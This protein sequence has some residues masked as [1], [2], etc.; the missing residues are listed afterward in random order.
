MRKIIT[1]IAIL[2]AG[3]SAFAQNNP[4]RSVSLRLGVPVGFSYQIYTGKKDH[5]EFVLGGASPYWSK[6]YYINSFNTF[7]KY[8]DFKYLDHSVKNTIFLQ[9]RYLK[10]FAIPTAGMDGS[11]TWY[12]GVGALLKVAKV[13][14]KYTNIQAIPPTQY[15]THTDIDFG[16]EAILGGE[17][18]LED[19]PF[20]FF[21][22]GSLMFE[23]L[24]RQTGRLFGAVGVRYHFF[25]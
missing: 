24:D 14:Y 19:T 18:W 1:I 7:S 6:H 20:S 8:K 2:C 4:V 13:E 17:Y 3:T 21:G 12:C 15:D 9:G 5:F 10:D 25:Q 23:I 16:P 22:E 11:L